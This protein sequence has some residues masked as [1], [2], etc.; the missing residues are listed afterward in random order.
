MMRLRP[1]LFACALCVLPIACAAAPSRVERSLTTGDKLR[2]IDA[3]RRGD[4]SW[5]AP[6]AGEVEIAAQRTRIGEWCDDL[7]ARLLAHPPSMYAEIDCDRALGAL[8]TSAEAY[9]RSAPRLFAPVDR[10]RSALE[11]AHAAGLLDDGELS[12]L[13]ELLVEQARRPAF[14][15]QS[16]RGPVLAASGG[17]WL[18]QWLDAYAI[19]ERV[20][21]AELPSGDPNP[22]WAKWTRPWRDPD[23]WVDPKTTSTP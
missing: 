16:E 13:L 4:Q 10:E 20:A 18:R 14:R 7:R 15:S 12:G 3:A 2:A 11:A 6:G 23:F 19:V 22:P 17:E 8:P 5:R 1:A 21:G 9:P